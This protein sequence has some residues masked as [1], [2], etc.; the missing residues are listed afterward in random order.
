[1][2]GDRQDQFIHEVGLICPESGLVLLISIEAARCA[3]KHQLKRD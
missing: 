1:M 3:V 2:T